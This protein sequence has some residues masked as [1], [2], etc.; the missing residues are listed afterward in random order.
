[1]A[2]G[3][4]GLVF[5]LALLVN[6]FNLLRKPVRRLL[7]G[8][9]VG[10]KLAAQRGEAFALRMYRAMAFGLIGVGLVALYFAARL[11]WSG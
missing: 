1:M 11:L 5:A 9:A 4:I 10:R 3:L 8:D 7:A 6:G 2:A